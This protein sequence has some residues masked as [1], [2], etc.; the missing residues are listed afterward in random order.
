[1]SS[2]YSQYGRPAACGANEIAKD[3]DGGALA[4]TI[5]TQ[6]TKDFTIGYGQAKVC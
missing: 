1:L 6:E 2:V 5:W 4:G 3:F